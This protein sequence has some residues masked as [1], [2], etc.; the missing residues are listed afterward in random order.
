MLFKY[1]LQVLVIPIL[2]IPVLVITLIFIDNTGNSISD[3]QSEIMEYKLNVIKDN[4]IAEFSVLER[5]KLESSDFYVTS[6]KEK[7]I[8]LSDGIDIPGGYVFIVDGSG[9]VVHHPEMTPKEFESLNVMDQFYMGADSEEATEAIRYRQGSDMYLAFYT[10]FDK[11]DWILVAT[12]KEEIIYSGINN[13]TRLSI[14]ASGLSV[15]LGIVLLAFIARSITRPIEILSET[16]RHMSERDLDVRVEINTRD[17]FGILAKSFNQMAEQLKQDFDKIHS[18]MEEIEKVS[19]ELQRNEHLFKGLFNNAFQLIGL[20]DTEGTLLEANET[21]MKLIDGDKASLIGK[22]FWETPWWSH[23]EEEQEKVKAAIK[24]AAE[25]EFV[26]DETYYITAEGKRMDIDY[27]VKPLMNDQGE[28]I[29]LVPEGRDIT[30]LKQSERELME[31]NDQLENRV[32]QRTNELRKTNQN[33]EISLSTLEE[34]Q[35]ELLDTK[36]ELELSIENLLQTQTQLVESEKLAA[37]GSLVAGI[38]HEMNTPIGMGLTSASFIQSEIKRLSRLYEEKELK[39]SVLELFIERTSD[40]AEITLTNLKR[41]SELV[42]G[43]KMIAVDQS[44]HKRRSFNLNEYIDEII[45]TLHPKLKRTYH[46]INIQ[47]PEGIILDS[48]P[49]ALSQI[50]SNLIINSL[51]HGF[52]DISAGIINIDA[53]AGEKYLTLVYKDNGCGIPTEDLPRIF[54]P[55]FTTKLGSGGSGLGLHIVYNLVTAVLQGE[56]ICEGSVDKGAT[57]VIKIPLKVSRMGIE[58]DRR[59]DEL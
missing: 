11:W 52:E 3:L 35:E 56:I 47:C 9:A 43:F 46:V 40:A 22:P 8:K 30:D 6:A 18:Q 26:R 4:C 28:V 38:S 33:L 44:S 2:I 12:A 37:L 39:K 42:T 5:L 59:G 55:F 29:M 31:L 13:S 49:G 14:F 27:S 54:E 48:Y 24:K 16:S 53:V 51:V 34:T 1:K 15:L 32:L 36:R 10:Y 21:S 23:S 20:L 45:K 25:G 17:E 19:E 57:F 7:I 50:L 58:G 41:A